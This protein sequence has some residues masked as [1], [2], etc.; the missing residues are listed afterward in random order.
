MQDRINLSPLHWGPKTW[1]F[2]ESAGIAYPKNP[3]DD[4]KTS[5]KNFIVSLKDLLPCET[6]RIHYN[7]FLKNTPDLDS[8]VRNRDSFIDYIVN[9]HNNVR[10]RNKQSELPISKVFKYYEDIYSTP[11]VPTETFTNNKLQKDNITENFSNIASDML[12]HFNPITLLIGV[13]I[14]L[15]IYKFYSDNVLANNR[16]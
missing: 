13:M 11:A 14:G 4:Q 2:L 10:V 5:A 3:T 1:F 6:C 15:I 7:E 9:L 12:F 8:V 16:N